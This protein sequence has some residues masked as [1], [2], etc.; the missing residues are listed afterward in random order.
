MSPY[1]ALNSI[2]KK[3]HQFFVQEY[4]LYEVLLRRSLRSYILNLLTAPVGFRIIERNSF[5]KLGLV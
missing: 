2:S 3:G 1:K 5:K 4:P